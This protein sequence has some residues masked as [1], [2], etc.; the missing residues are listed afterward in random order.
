ML[1]ELKQRKR[2]FA[3]VVDELG[4]TASV[5]TIEDILEQLVGEI[6]DEYD[7]SDPVIA[8]DDASMVLDGATNIRDLEAD[9]HVSVPRDEGYETLA[10]FVL[11][12]LQRIPANG[13]SFEF[14]GRRFTVVGMDGHRV[15]SVKIKAPQPQPPS[16]AVL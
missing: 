12:K 15:E 9:Y 11:A 7:V 14:E 10:G 16:P 6:E 3:V 2:Y 13:D 4:S 1:T 5:V 8:P